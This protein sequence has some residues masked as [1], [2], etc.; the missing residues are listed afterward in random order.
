MVHVALL[1]LM[2]EAA[3]REPRFHYQPEAQ[4]H[5]SPAIHKPGGRLPHL[6]GEHPPRIRA[7]GRRSA[8]PS[9][10]LSGGSPPIIGAM[11]KAHSP[12]MLAASD[13]GVGGVL[14][15]NLNRPGANVTG[16]ASL[17]TELTAKQLQLL[18][19][20]IANAAAFGVVADTFRVSS[21]PIGS[22]IR[23]PVC[24]P[25]ES[26]GDSDCSNPPRRSR[27]KPSPPSPPRFCARS[28]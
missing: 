18:H 10:T 24:R 17:A 11:R 14:V 4:H 6:T 20:L 8:R 22:P 28:V 25:A 5:K 21:C 19:E 2:L 26:G 9:L 12:S 16:I 1:L 7:P 3:K 27:R 15:A 13:K 23:N